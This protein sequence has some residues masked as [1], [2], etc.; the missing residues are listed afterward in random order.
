L[1]KNASGRGST[2]LFGV[3][4]FLSCLNAIYSLVELAVTGPQADINILFML[5]GTF[6]VPISFYFLT[7]VLVAT[8]CFGYFCS[9]IIRKLTIESTATKMF[10]VVEE[11]S[12]HNQEQLE[13]AFTKKFA[14]LS[15]DE[16]E[17]AEALKSIKMQLR[18]NQKRIQEIG[19]MRGKYGV[20]L[21]RQTVVL[22]EIKKKTEKM[23]SL[24]APKC[25]LNGCSDIQE[26]GGVD[27]KMAEKLKSVGITHVEDLITEYPRKI[28]LSTRIPKR[29]IEKIQAAAQFL[30]IPGIDRKRAKLL[31]KAGITSAKKLADQD[32]IQLLKKLASVTENIDDRPTLE[33]IASYIKFAQSGFSVFY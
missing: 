31:Q 26:I 17:V 6:Y 1:S 25:L 13:K 15:M 8:L 19:E 32:P 4:V 30:M 24:L 23:E 20:T 11:K 22:K 10:D 29:K 21:K 12:R 33:E 7:S 5:G 9:L 2:W 16:F 28:A 3:I 27:K 14:E 18:E